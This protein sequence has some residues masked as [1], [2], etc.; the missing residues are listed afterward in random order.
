MILGCFSLYCLNIAVWDST[1]WIFFRM[2]AVVEVAEKERYSRR[3]YRG[4]SCGFHVVAPFS[5]E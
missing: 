2:Q 4:Y 1:E 5:L 3:G